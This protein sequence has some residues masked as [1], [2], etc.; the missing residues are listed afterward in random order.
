MNWREAE[1][2]S[3]EQE[4]GTPLAAVGL[5]TR[6]WRWRGALAGQPLQVGVWEGCARMLQATLPVQGSP[7]GLA[8]GGAPQ[9]L[10]AVVAAGSANSYQAVCATLPER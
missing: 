1:V 7:A 3:G 8:I 2:L 6:R 10:C 9:Q 4:A 5:D